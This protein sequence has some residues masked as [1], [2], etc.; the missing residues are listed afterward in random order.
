[1]QVVPSSKIAISCHGILINKMSKLTVKNRTLVRHLVN[2]NV[3]CTQ[4]LL[5]SKILTFEIA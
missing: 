2:V 1:M 5:S 3:K 4:V